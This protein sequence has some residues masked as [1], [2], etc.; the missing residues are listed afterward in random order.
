MPDERGTAEQ[1]ARNCAVSDARYT[2]SL[3]ILNRGLAK[4]GEIV[5]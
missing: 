1:A 3:E 4:T 5:G 2:G